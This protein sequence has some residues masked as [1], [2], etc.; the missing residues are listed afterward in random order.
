MKTITINTIVDG[1]VDAKQVNLWD[2]A[3]VDSRK[4]VKG[5]LKHGD[6]ATVMNGDGDYVE[7]KAMGYKWDADLQKEITGEQVRGWCNKAFVKYVD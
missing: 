7:L 5:Y 3:E 2:V 1:G 4:K 6:E